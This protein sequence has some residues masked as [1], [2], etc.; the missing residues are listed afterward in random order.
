MSGKL[1]SGAA[2]ASNATRKPV[3]PIADVS[4]YQKSPCSQASRWLAA[5]AGRHL[6]Q[7]PGFK[8]KSQAFTNWLQRVRLC[9]EFQP[10]AKQKASCCTQL[11]HATLTN[12]VF[13]DDK[14]HACFCNIWR[15]EIEE[16]P[17]QRTSR[18]TNIAHPQG[19]KPGEGQK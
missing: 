1:D 14:K 2:V 13:T 10:A 6:T 19:A 16:T 18:K 3:V 15:E 5:I 17:C 4:R 11:P 9:I 7:W 12:H 8:P